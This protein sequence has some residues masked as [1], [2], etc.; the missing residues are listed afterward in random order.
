MADCL[1]R[2][3]TGNHDSGRSPEAAKSKEIWR[4]LAKNQLVDELEIKRTEAGTRCRETL[5]IVEK[6]LTEGRRR[7]LKGSSVQELV[8]MIGWSHGNCSD[9]EYLGNL[10][11]AISAKRLL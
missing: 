6:R 8:K 10:E 3:L 7:P 4:L 5:S 1:M 2:K 9:E 11:H